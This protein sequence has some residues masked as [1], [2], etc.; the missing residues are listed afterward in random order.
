MRHNFLDTFQLCDWIIMNI[1]GSFYYFHIEILRVHFVR[2]P[3][4][5]IKIYRNIKKSIP[6]LALR[7]VL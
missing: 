6:A 5:I 3:E 1:Y 2:M 7:N 4:N